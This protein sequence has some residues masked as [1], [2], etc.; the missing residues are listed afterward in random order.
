M[1]NGA[2]SQI[3]FTDTV[4]LIVIGSVARGTWEWDSDLDL[5]WIHRGHRPRTWRDHLLKWYGGPV[6]LLPFNLT[7]VR[8]HFR[9]H[10]PMA[11]AIQHGIPLYDREG[12]HGKWQRVSLGLPSRQWIDE[13]YD[14]MWY[15]FEWGMDSYGRERDF[16]RRERHATD[17]CFC[18]VSEL[19]TRAT[20]N[21]VRLR[22][23][24]P[25]GCG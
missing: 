18:R 14:F 4:A 5:V 11:H 1:P 17:D 9:Q 21:L 25:G 15:R 24:A 7:Q 12:Q 16:H 2:D 6:E 13:T 20:L 22:S 10:S 8:R 23:I 3:L 19:L